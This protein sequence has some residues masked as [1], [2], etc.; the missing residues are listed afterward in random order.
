MEG[1]PTPVITLEKLKPRLRYDVAES[2]AKFFSQDYLKTRRG[3]SEMRKGLAEVSKGQTLVELNRDLILSAQ[4]IQTLVLKEDSKQIFADIY[5]K[6]LDKEIDSRSEEVMMR[7]LERRQ[8]IPTIILELIGTDEACTKAVRELFQEVLQREPDS[9]G[10]NYYLDLLK[11]GMSL[12]QIAKMM[13]GSKEYRELPHDKKPKYTFKGKSL[14]EALKDLPEA[15]F[16]KGNAKYSFVNDVHNIVQS[17]ENLPA[18]GDA[19]FVETGTGWWTKDPIG[20]LKAMEAVPSLSMN[21]MLK[22]INSDGTPVVFWDLEGEFLTSMPDVGV[23]AAEAGTGIYLLSKAFKKEKAEVNDNSL[24]RITRRRLGKI[25]MGVLGSW[26]A[27]PSTSMVLTLMKKLTGLDSQVINSFDRAQ[28]AIHPEESLYLLT[29]RN[30]ILAE[31]EEWL[32]KKWGGGK[33]FV[34]I[35]GSFHFEKGVHTVEDELKRS[36]EERIDFLGNPLVKPILTTLADPESIY[37]IVVIRQDE[38]NG[39]RREERYIVPELYKLVHGPDAKLPDLK[40]N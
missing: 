13:K 18:N 28:A 23:F 10:G 3:V 30:S 17:P 21:K 33:H 36:S 9:S 24:S 19:F 37:T 6:V 2:Y 40:S 5:G 14:E 34:T 4:Y 29:I 20:H 26:F 11:R 31:K 27:V 35:A 8:S 22:Q 12:E 1:S 16:I 7:G 15:D 38:T 39:T 32:Q 25:G